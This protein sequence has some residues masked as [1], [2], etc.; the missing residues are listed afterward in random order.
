[1]RLDRLKLLVSGRA[2]VPRLESDDKE[3]V[4]AGANKTEQTEADDAGLV[5]HPRCVR[6]NVFYLCPCL[7]CSL[8]RRVIGQLQIHIDIAL[9]FIGKKARRYPIG[10]ESRRE[11]KD[12][13]KHNHH[14]CFLEQDTAPTDIAFSGPLKNPVKPVEESPQQAMAL[15]ARSKKQCSQGW[16][17]RKRVESGENYRDR[18]R[19]R[20]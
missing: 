16:A 9:I 3:S 5:F 18:D 8:E 6:Q 12:Q 2:L 7:R 11:A 4:V 1:M 19:D 14:C 13:Q 17:E 15:F 10:E 20:E